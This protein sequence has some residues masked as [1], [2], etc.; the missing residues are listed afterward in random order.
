MQYIAS[1]LRLPPPRPSPSLDT[2]LIGPR[3]NI[4]AGDTVD[5]KQWRTLRELSRDTLVPWE[6]LWP[7]DALSYS[8]YASLLRRQ[9]RDWRR[10]TAYAFNIFRHSPSQP[11]YLVG[12]ITLGEVQHASAQKGTLGYWIGKPYTGQGLMTEAVGL[13]CDFAFNTL[14]LH[15]VEASC[16]PANLASQAVLRKA[17]FIQEGF[18]KGYLQINGVREDHLLWGRNK[19]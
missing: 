4:R 13:V 15:R 2:L 12:G 10:G 14:R 18:A 17:G 7:E 8:F 19:S 16:M 1:L 11:S 9:W 6:P 5:W 3:L